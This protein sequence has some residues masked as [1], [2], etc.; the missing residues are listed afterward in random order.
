MANKIHTIPIVKLTTGSLDNKDVEKAL[1]YILELIRSNIDK[2]DFIKYKGELLTAT[3]ELNLVTNAKSGYKYG[4]AWLWVSSLALFHLL[5]GKN[6]DGTNAFRTEVIPDWKIPDLGF[7]PTSFNINVEG[8]AKQLFESRG[9]NRKNWADITSFDEYIQELA[10][11]PTIQIPQNIIT[12]PGIQLTE[13]QYKELCA[14]IK[15]EGKSIDNIPTIY[16]MKVEASYFNEDN[17]VTLKCSSVPEFVTEDIL[18]PYFSKFNTDPHVYQHRITLTNGDKKIIS[19]TFPMIRFSPVSNSNV[20]CA[21]IQ[22]S[23]HPEHVNDAKGANLMRKQ[24]KIT[25]KRGNIHN[26][27]FFPWNQDQEHQAQRSASH[28][29]PK[30]GK[31]SEK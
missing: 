10:T 14:S 23:K 30:F 13:I 1:N 9:Y 20:K 29:P 27:I 16:N 2:E 28:I 18:Y 24:L 11:P 26:L 21:Y 6:C 31:L 15:N 12:I 3:Y 8:P 4:L 5:C 25:D 7:D 17:C 22:Y 19:K